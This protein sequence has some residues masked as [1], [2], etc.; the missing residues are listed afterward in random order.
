MA[1]QY[2][3]WQCISVFKNTFPIYVQCLMHNENE[4]SIISFIFAISY[5]S[6]NM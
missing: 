5:T 6:F 2:V 3:K 4:N 1:M